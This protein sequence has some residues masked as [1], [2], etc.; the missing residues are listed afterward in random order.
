MDRSWVS[1]LPIPGSVIYHRK[2]TRD[3]HDINI[4]KLIE[5]EIVR[6]GRGGH[7]V[8]I[9]EVLIDL[10]CGNIELVNN[11]LLNKTLV[12]CGLITILLIVKLR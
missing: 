5:P 12:A 11:P 3:T 4:T 2:L 7:E 8:S 9:R 10:F 6:G 1:W